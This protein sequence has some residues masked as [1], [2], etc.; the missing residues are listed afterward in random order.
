MTH[1]SDLPSPNALG[2]LMLAVEDLET[3]RTREVTPLGL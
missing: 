3:F 2:Q 1:K